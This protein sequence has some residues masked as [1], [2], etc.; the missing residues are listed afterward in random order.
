MPQPEGLLVK[1]IIP[2]VLIGLAFGLWVRPESYFYAKAFR[3]AH[4]TTNAVVDGVEYAIREGTVL[5]GDTTITGAER[6]RALTLAYAAT[7]AERSPQ[8]G[9]PGTDPEELEKQV[10]ELARVQQEQAE[11]LRIPS[12]IYYARTALYPIS[13]LRALAKVERERHAFIASH[14]DADL[15]SYLAA[16]EQ[17]IEAQRRDGAL[18]LEAY[19][20]LGFTSAKFPQLG[21]TVTSDKVEAALAGIEEAADANADTLRAR[22]SCFSGTTRACDT[23]DITLPTPQEVSATRDA[24]AE[25]F[26]KEV[27]SIKRQAYQDGTTAAYTVA[28]AKSACVASVAGPYIFKIPDP[29]KPASYPTAAASFLGDYFFS[30]SSTSARALSKGLVTASITLINPMTFYQCFDKGQDVS[31]TRAVALVY[32]FAKSHSGI[33]AQTR[34]ALLDS[35]ILHEEDAVAYLR[36]ALQELPSYELADQSELIS[37]ALTFRNNSAGL[38][39]VVNEIWSLSETNLRLR[40]MGYPFDDSLGFLVGSHSGFADLLQLHNPS[41]VP[42]TPEIYD[43]STAALGALR[44]KLRRY[45]QTAPAYRSDIMRYLREFRA[46]ERRAR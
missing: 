44:D 33:A 23:R 28:L 4:I 14:S 15:R 13:F 38:D 11:S 3:S 31:R 35:P 27:E 24:E 9:I 42:G 16:I 20:F 21:G 8:F 10:N 45:S 19:K 25:R 18:F 37:L 32:L 41:V 5:R 40:Q 30:A 1:L 26:A 2:V 46:F 34:T 36:E 17:A 7:V 43:R 39:L 22:R 6:L 29:A 12:N